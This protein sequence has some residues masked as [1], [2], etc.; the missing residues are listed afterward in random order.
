MRLQ[1]WWIEKTVQVQYTQSFLRSAILYCMT[2]RLKCEILYSIDKFYIKYAHLM[3]DLI[4]KMS[5]NYTARESIIINMHSKPQF[6]HFQ[7]SE[8]LVLHYITPY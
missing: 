2:C 3:A 4:G 6:H 7:S 1:L 5:R 8:S